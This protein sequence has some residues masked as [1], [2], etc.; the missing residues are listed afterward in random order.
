L[1]QDYVLRA[2]TKSHLEHNGKILIC[3]VCKKSLKLGEKVH[4]S[5]CSRNYYHQACFKKLYH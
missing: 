4:R 3:P 1:P 5:S 2:T